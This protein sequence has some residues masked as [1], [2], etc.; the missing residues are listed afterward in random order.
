M[1]Q[2]TQ[3]VT[4]PWEELVTSAFCIYLTCAIFSL[5][6]SLSN[7]VIFW[8]SLTI[9]GAAGAHI[10]VQAWFVTGETRVLV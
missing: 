7:I 8:S 1:N 5:S 2:G 9:V 10:P 4:P 6:I 3:I